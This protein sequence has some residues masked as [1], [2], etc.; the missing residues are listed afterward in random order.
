M[1]LVDPSAWI[2]LLRDTASAGDPIRM[3][4]P[5]GARDDLHLGQLRGLLARAT[6]IDVT[7]THYEDAVT[8]MLV[9][10]PIL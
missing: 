1:I 8:S 10:S 4:I 3:E 7:S 2:E 9:N 5:A 6:N